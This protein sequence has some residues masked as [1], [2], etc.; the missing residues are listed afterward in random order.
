MPQTNP[1]G[2]PHAHLKLDLRKVYLQS[3]TETHSHVILSLAIFRQLYHIELVK[4][5]FSL[6]FIYIPIFSFS[7]QYNQNSIKRMQKITTFQRHPHC[8]SGKEPE[9]LS[10]TFYKIFLK[11]QKK[12]ERNLI[13][14]V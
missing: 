9:N 13:L 2:L 4:P 6:V 8:L 11:M 12:K 5:P 3:M 1:T 10:K 14:S 7:L